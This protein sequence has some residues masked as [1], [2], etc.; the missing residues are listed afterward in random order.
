MYLVKPS[1]YYK[2][3]RLSMGYLNFDSFYFFPSMTP[4]GTFASLK[5]VN[6]CI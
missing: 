5:R 4:I 3:L 6:L 2:S 1:Y